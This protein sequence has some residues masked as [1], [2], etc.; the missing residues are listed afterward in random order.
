MSANEDDVG[1]SVTGS[2]GV[3]TRRVPAVPCGVAASEHD[4]TTSCIGIP[5]RVKTEQAMQVVMEAGNVSPLDVA[6]TVTAQGGIGRLSD[7][8]C[9]F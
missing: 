2:D 1:L 8:G 6:D 9:D 7:E 5:G 4:G 3:S